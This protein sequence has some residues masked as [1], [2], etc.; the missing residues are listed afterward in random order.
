MQ[1][2]LEVG[3]DAQPLHVASDLHLLPANHGNVVLRVATHDTRVTPRATIQID[4]HTPRVL[5]LQRRGISLLIVPRCRE[6]RI[7]LTRRLALWRITNLVDQRSACSTLVCKVRILLNLGDRRIPNDR[8]LLRLMTRERIDT[9]FIRKRLLQILLRKT[10]AVLDVMNLRNAQLIL[11]RHLY[12]SCAR[13]E[14][15]P[16]CSTNLVRVKSNTLRYA[17]SLYTAAKP[18]MSRNHTIRVTWHHQ[19]RRNKLTAV[20]RNLH[21]IGLLQ[22]DVAHR[23]HAHHRGVVPAQVRHL[24]RQLLHPADV[25]KPS[26][27]DRRIGPERNLK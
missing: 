21:R 5:N 16:I 17:A 14:Q 23:S 27:I 1:V 13:E 26:I 25:R 12:R 4:R 7:L 3:I 24:L 20:E 6:E 19:R 8:P 11:T 10:A 18:K 9:V 15:C 2:A 22:L